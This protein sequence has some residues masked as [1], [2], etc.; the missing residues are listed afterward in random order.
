MTNP[1]PPGSLGLLGL[2]ETLA[3]VSNPFAFFERRIERHGPVFKTRILGERVI[4][5]AGSEG[6]AFLNDERYFTRQGSSPPAVQELLHREA[7]PFLGGEAHRRRKRLLLAPFSEEALASYVPLVCTI[8]QRYLA[9]WRARDAPFAWL[10]QLDALC[11]DIANALFAGADPESSNPTV[12]AAVKALADGMLALPVKLPF[13]TYGKALRARD[14]LRRYVAEMVAQ[15]SGDG[16]R[17][18]LGWLAEARA[19]DGKGLTAEEME[20]ETLHFFMA[21]HGALTGVL[22]ATVLALAQQPKATEL[23]RAEALEHAAEGTPTFETLARLSY[24]DRLGREIR[25]HSR[26]LPMTFF[27]TVKA[28]CEFGGYSLPA[29]WKAVGCIHATHVDAKSWPLPESFD[30]DRFADERFPAGYCPQGGGPADGHRCAG[31]PLTD[32]V[33][34]L[35]IAMLLRELEWSLPPQDLRPPSGPSL[36]PLPRSGIVAQLRPRALASSSS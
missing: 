26:L 10:P 32:M 34:S 14:E 1:V 21:G 20:I 35:F 36:L 31:E 2:A 30:P 9:R 17:H 11:F 33:L 27:A 6:I 5:L 4:C 13:T 8:V 16:P 12:L 28:D 7:V 19:D 25:R 29:G 3:F 22:A 18:V 23:A 15:H 24:V